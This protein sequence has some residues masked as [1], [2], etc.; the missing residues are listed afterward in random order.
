MS[1]NGFYALALDVHFIQEFAPA[2]LKKAS[3]EIVER[4]Q[5]LTKGIDLPSDKWLTKNMS[6][7]LKQCRC[8]VCCKNDLIMKWIDNED[9]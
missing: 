3:E 4:A 7:G 6:E 1:D 9:P 2:S 8:V 5:G